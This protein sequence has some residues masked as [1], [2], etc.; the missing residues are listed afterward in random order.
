MRRAEI[1]RRNKISP[2]VLS[3]QDG[4]RSLVIRAVLKSPHF[5]LFFVKDSP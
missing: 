4:L 3:R 5:F 1:G 2:G